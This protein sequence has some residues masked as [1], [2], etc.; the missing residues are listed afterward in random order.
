[1]SGRS[2]TEEVGRET[3]EALDLLKQSEN[4][5]DDEP[6]NGNASSSLA[7][8]NSKPLT[9]EDEEIIKEYFR[10]HDVRAVCRTLWNQIVSAAF[11]HMAKPLYKL[12]SLDEED[13]H[14][15][16][17]EA[18]FSYIVR[19]YIFYCPCLQAIIF[20]CPRLRAFTPHRA[21]CLFFLDRAASPDGPRA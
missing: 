12:S 1:M 11:R 21:C 5:H 8:G 14:P 19:S 7:N 16:T 9:G 2:E 13:N 4:L 18:Y 15:K 20:H 10:Q 3:Q 6:D 17:L